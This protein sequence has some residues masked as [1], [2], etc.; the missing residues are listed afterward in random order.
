MRSFSQG[1]Q[2]ALERADSFG[3][4]AIANISRTI[5]YTV[6]KWPLHQHADSYW[7]AT[8]QLFEMPLVWL[9]A[10]CSFHPQDRH[11]MDEHCAVNPIHGLSR[12]RQDKKPFSS[13]PWTWGDGVSL[14]S[15]RVLRLSTKCKLLLD[16]DLYI[17]LEGLSKPHNMP[18]FRLA[19]QK[20]SSI[21]TFGAPFLSQIAV[22]RACPSDIWQNI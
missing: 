12:W 10:S 5:L 21:Q 19:S 2:W 6:C 15:C 13:G 17:I 16:L 7:V 9:S 8:Q 3:I 4:T 11:N 20:S 1:Q 18:A 22:I 14:V